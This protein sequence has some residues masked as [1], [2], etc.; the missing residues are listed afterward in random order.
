MLSKYEMIG[1]GFSV[2]I[3]A[4]ALYLVRLE[5]TIL[6]GV[7][8]NTQSATAVKGIVSVTGG[9]DI[10]QSRTEALTAAADSKG[11]LKKI[12]IED[13][14][15][16]NGA[17]VVEGSTVIVHYEG[18]LQN[19]DEFDNSNKRGEPFSFTVGE[20]R[21]IK[22]WEEGLLGMKVGGKRIRSVCDLKDDITSHTTG[23]NMMIVPNSRYRYV[24]TSTAS[25]RVLPRVR[26][27]KSRTLFIKTPHSNAQP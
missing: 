13:I 6:A 19:G 17:V 18:R 1:V 27:R 24:R 23:P 8:S 4:V 15:L 9:G 12:V 7:D 5:T 10:E 14:T 2:V 25:R 26:V 20:G 3:M 21:V 22:G 11:N 16:G